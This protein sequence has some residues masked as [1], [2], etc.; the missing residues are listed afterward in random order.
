MRF[1]PHL[2][3]LTARK[4]LRELQRKGANGRGLTGAPVQ[5]EQDRREGRMDDTL[6]WGR[7][8]QQA[9]VIAVK[10]PR[11]ASL[12]CRNVA[13]LPPESPDNEGL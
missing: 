12:T 3:K 8:A 2:D 13:A 5:G 1:G 10:R 4:P 7:A 9:I 11:I 6:F